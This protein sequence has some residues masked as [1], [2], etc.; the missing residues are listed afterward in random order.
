LSKRKRSELWT[1][2]W[3]QADTAALEDVFLSRFRWTF[4]FFL[5]TVFRRAFFSAKMR[6]GSFSAANNLAAMFLFLVAAVNA[7]TSLPATIRIG[8]RSSRDQGPML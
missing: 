3:A 7:E 6:E 2:D 1:L 4:Y 8:A 5:Q